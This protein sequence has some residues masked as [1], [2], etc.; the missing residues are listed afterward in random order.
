MTRLGRFVF[1]MFLVCI[2]LVI[3]VWAVMCRGSKTKDWR[4]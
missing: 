3:V 1:S 4:K 2:A